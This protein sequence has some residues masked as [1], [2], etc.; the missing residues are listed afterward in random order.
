MPSTGLFPR[1]RNADDDVECVTRCHSLN[2]IVSSFTIGGDVEC[3]TRW[4]SLNGI[5][6]SFT[7]GGDVEWV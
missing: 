2:G 7:I 3:V 1:L 6:S 5:V 4:H